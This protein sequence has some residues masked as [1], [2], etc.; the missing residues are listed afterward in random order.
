MASCSFFQLS[1]FVASIDMV[2]LKLK[3]TSNFLW[4]SPHPTDIKCRKLEVGNPK[5]EV[6]SQKSEVSSRKSVFGS[7]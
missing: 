1:C 5:P 7:W 6:E 4:P 3:C 2:L